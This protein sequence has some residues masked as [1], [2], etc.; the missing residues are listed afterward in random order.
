MVIY[1]INLKE[2]SLVASLD[3]ILSKKRITKAQT[4]L[5]GCSGWSAPLLFALPEDR[6]SHAKV[7]LLPV[8]SEEYEVSLIME[9]DYSPTME[10]RIMWK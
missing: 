8:M 7:H 3:M 6:F 1:F 2:Y 10:L 4:S 9:G 5:C